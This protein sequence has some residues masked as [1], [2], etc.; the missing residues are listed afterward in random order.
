M[1]APDPLVEHAMHAECALH[2]SYIAI[3]VGSYVY[4]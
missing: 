4:N 2:I 1:H 3:Y